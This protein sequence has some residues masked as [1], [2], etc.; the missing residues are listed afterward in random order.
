MF[1]YKKDYLSKFINVYLGIIL[2]GIQINAKAMR[3]I[4][5]L[6]RSMKITPQQV[7]DNALSDYFAEHLDTTWK[8]KLSLKKKK[9]VPWS[10]KIPETEY[11]PP[12]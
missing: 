4:M 2:S 3:K 10:G 7:V 5:E 11:D 8:E 12:K 9:G 6:A 1:I